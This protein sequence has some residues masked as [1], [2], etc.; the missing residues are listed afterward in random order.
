MIDYIKRLLSPAA[1][2]RYSVGLVGESY[3]QPAIRRC[4]V[5]D[6]VTLRHDVGNAHDAR[7]IAAFARNQQ[8]GFLPR[9]GWLT[10]AII[11]EGKTVSATISSMAASGGGHTGVVLGVNW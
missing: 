6:A 10:R 9:D 1:T 5:G 7:A 11:D 4:T 8:I 2:Y 3:R